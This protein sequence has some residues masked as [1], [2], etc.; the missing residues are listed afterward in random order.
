MPAENESIAASAAPQQNA[1]EQA[2]PEA[3]K[4]KNQEK[5][6][7]K[8]KAKMEKFLAKQAKKATATAGGADAG[9]KKEKEPKA[10]AKPKNKPV[11]VNT[12]PKGEK[13]DMS[14][15]MADSYDPVAVESAW[16]EWWEKEGF[17]GPEWE[18][19]GETSPKGKFVMATPPPNVTG[20]LHIGHALFIAIQD[21]IVRWNRMRGVTTV[22]VP[23]ADHA[24]ISTQA[25]VEKQLWKQEKK[26]RHDLGRE[27]FVDKVWEWKEEYGHSIMKQIRRLGASY[28]WSRERFT[29]DGMLSRATRETFVRLFDDGIIYRSSR[30]VNWCHHLNTALSN[31]EV[32][33]L[34]LPGRTLKSVPGYPANEKFEFGVL[35][36]FAYE[37]EDSDERIIVATTRIE[38]M[39]G[40]TAI[41]IHPEDKRYTHL[42]GKFVKHPFIDRRIPIIT[43]SE[44]VDMAFG[45]GA[46]KITPAHD[47]NDYA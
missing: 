12:T 26:T 13:K 20:K 38:T 23:G 25:V 37:V 34:E 18:G 5:N 19:N 22:F 45:T 40:D 39:L 8:R 17:F 11:F 44:A 41:A 1:A 46:V 3:A 32:E 9:A 31:L 10:A 36:H 28:D 2:T 6:D 27:A 7:A 43:D 35:V 47:H 15:P 30:L 42:H 21:S 16:Y 24:G 4:S 33:N 14:Q 29:L